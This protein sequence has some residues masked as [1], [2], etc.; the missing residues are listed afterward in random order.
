MGMIKK[1]SGTLSAGNAIGTNIGFIRVISSLG[2][3][4]YGTNLGVFNIQ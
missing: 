1:I 3:D 2:G 4:V